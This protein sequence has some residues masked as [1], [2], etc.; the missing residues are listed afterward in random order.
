MDK[1][2]A[3]LIRDILSGD[4]T[5]FTILVKK[6][7]KSVHALVWQKI[8]DFHYA[9]EIT[10]DAFLRAYKKLSTLR[11][12]HQF[13]GWLYVIANRCCISWT[14]KQKHAL[15]LMED[16]SVKEIGELTYE[17]YI[18]EQRE[19]E[20]TERRYEIVKKLLEKLPESERTVVTLY[21]LSE[22]TT[23]EIGK[24]LGVSAN[25]IHSR[26]HRAR[27]RLQK[28]EELLVQEVLGRVQISEN[29]IENI[30]RKVVNLK[31]TPVPT[32]KPLLPWVAFS[33]TAIC[34]LLLLSASNQY[35]AHFQK[36]YSFEAQSEPTIVIIDAPVRS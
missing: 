28:H 24:F 29:L 15:Q 32:G 8:G 7:H 14:R 11:N 12:P 27:E 9:E 19:I 16:T 5:A 21:Y 34:L 20:A 31:P 26:L 35:L 36:P 18:S 25:T 1:S 2:D 6:Y 30:A 33:A 3:Q 10:Q 4:D 17:R 13:A 23:K 22:M